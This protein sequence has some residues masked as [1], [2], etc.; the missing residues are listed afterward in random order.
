MIGSGC[1]S[2]NK[3]KEGMRKIAERIYGK[4]LD[5][6]VKIHNI[7]ATGNF[8]K[9]VDLE[10][11]GKLSGVYRWLYEPEQ[12]PA[13]IVW[14]LNENRPCSLLYENGKFNAVGAKSMEEL[15]E[16]INRLH[17]NL[18]TLGLLLPKARERIQ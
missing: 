10:N 5:L 16:W 13:G 6:D 7:V 11:L 18:R 1:K 4:N 2:V 14:P 15:E 3:A 12:F 17:Y 8:N 9:N